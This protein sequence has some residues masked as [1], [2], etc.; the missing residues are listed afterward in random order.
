LAGAERSVQTKRLRSGRVWAGIPPLIIVLLKKR[1]IKKIYK[2]MVEKS[3]KQ[4]D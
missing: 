3:W 2:F 1:A 4:S